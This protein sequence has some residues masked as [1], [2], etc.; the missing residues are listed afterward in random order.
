MQ[1]LGVNEPEAFRALQEA[2]RGSRRRLVEVAQE[3]IDA[4]VG[5]LPAWVAPPGS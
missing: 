5:A 1:R 4:P 3:V 2:S